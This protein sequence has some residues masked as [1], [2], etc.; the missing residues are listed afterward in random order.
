MLGSTY[1]VISKDSGERL[2]MSSVPRRTVYA[3]EG[4]ETSH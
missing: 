4:L 2:L 1:H 3:E